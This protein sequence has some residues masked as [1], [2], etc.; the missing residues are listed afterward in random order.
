MLQGLFNLDL[1]L[2]LGAVFTKGL[3]QTLGLSWLYLNTKV[4]PKAWLRPFMNKKS[5]VSSIN[6]LHSSNY[7]INFKYNFIIVPLNH[8]SCDTAIQR[9]ISIIE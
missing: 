3:S 7:F 5:E 8:T 2:V 4:K 1:S 6:Y 9:S